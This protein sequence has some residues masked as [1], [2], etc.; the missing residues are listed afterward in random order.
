[1]GETVALIVAAGRGERAAKPGTS[2]EFPK[3]YWALAG[4]PVL[5]KQTDS[6]GKKLLR[7]R[8]GVNQL[9]LGP[10]DQNRHGQRRGN[11]SSKIRRRRRGMSDEIGGS[12][13]H[14]LSNTTRCL[15]ARQFPYSGRP[16]KKPLNSNH[17]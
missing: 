6:H 2:G 14:L 15:S 4:Q 5:Q 17:G 13:A 3:Q 12:F 1:M 11:G 8:I 9:I 7:C 16:A 10:D